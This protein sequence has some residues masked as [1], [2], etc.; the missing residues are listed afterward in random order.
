L[1]REI[2]EL[3]IAISEVK[4]GMMVGGDNPNSKGYSGGLG[5]CLKILRWVAPADKGARSIS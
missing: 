2:E 5:V 1:E 4:A 3:N